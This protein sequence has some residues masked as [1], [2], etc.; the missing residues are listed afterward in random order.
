MTSER[1]MRTGYTSGFAVWKILYI[2]MAVIGL[3][4]AFPLAGSLIINYQTGEGEHYGYIT[5]VGTSGLVF[6]TTTVHFKSDAQSSQEDSYCAKDQAVIAKLREYGD[7][8]KRVRIHYKDYFSYASGCMF[9][10]GWVIDS[11][12][13]P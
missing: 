6:K 10:S 13:L 11:V 1:R 9:D 2:P 8:G 5:A 3:A 7:S 12:E 4:L